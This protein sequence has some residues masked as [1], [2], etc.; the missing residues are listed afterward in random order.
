MLFKNLQSILSQLTDLLQNPLRIRIACGQH[1]CPVN[2]FSWSVLWMYAK[3]Q[4]CSNSGIKNAFLMCVLLIWG[5]IRGFGFT[6][7]SSR[8]EWT[9][10]SVENKKEPKIVLCKMSEADARRVWRQ[11]CAVRLAR[12]LLS[13]VCL[14]LWNTLWSEPSSICKRSPAVLCLPFLSALLS[15]GSPLFVF[16]SGSL[17]CMSPGATSSSQQVLIASSTLRHKQRVKQP[18]ELRKVASTNASELVLLFKKKI[19]QKLNCLKHLLF[20]LYTLS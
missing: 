14:R 4:L 10:N 15:S 12:C 13:L 20:W 19:A 9:G 1:I 7:Q 17:S 5:S 16:W 2:P 18:L 11:G 8:E 6:N 3:C